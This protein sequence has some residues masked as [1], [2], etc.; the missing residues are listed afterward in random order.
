MSR[1]DLREYRALPQVKYVACFRLA[2]SVFLGAL[3]AW[4]LYR[5]YLQATDGMLDPLRLTGV[6][7]IF[8]IL[9]LFIFVVAAMRPQAV[10][11]IVDASGLRLEYLHGSP[12]A[13]SWEGP[14]TRLQGRYTIG[15]SA[16]AHGGKP[17]CSVF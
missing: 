16:L 3:S 11:L 17:I 6:I 7:L 10:D 5:T 12:Y 1:Y 13:K 14:R 9:G 8:F 4:I 2:F 15:D